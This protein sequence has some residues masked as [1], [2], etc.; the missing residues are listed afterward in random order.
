MQI[1]RKITVGT[2]NGIR[3]GFVVAEGE[4]RLVGRIYGMAGAVET[5]ESTYGPYQRFK[6]EF[7]AINED[8]EEI[9]APILM[10]PEPASGMLAAALATE[11][12]KSGVQFGFDIFVQ[13]TPKKQPGDRGYQYVIK[14]LLETAPSDPLKALAASLPALPAPAAPKQAALTGVD[15]AMQSA[16]EPAPATE[17]AP[18]PAQEKAN[19]KKK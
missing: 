4:T 12:G 3:G 9:G 8:G 17:A 19:N 14:P 13:S 16:A 11:S 2:I 7:R 5:K 1:A 10:L 15:P 18:A 6:G